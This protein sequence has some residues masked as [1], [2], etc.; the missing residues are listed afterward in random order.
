MIELRVTKIASKHFIERLFDS[1][2]IFHCCLLYNRHVMSLL[3][4]LFDEF[5]ILEAPMIKRLFEIL[6]VNFLKVW[7]LVI[8]LSDQVLQLVTKPKA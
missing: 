6:S 8:L 4:E 7:K 3:L 1:V 5:F 2:K